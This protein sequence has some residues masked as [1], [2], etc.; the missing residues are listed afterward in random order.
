[1][2]CNSH[3]AAPQPT[4]LG[5]ALSAALQ[6]V[7]PDNPDVPSSAAVEE[8]DCKVYAIHMN[9]SAWGIPALRNAN[10]RFDFDRRLTTE[11]LYVGET[12][13]SIE[14][15]Y[16][17]HRTEGRRASTKWGRRHFKDS[18]REAYD[19]SIRKLRKEYG[20]ERNVDLDALTRS[21]ARYHEKHFAL[22]LRQ[23]GYAVYFA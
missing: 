21:E 3:P 4:S 2:N 16:R 8:R 23:R 22:W 9:P 15:R 17:V 20:K 13:K 14:E 7:V 19:R 1:M 10:P 11:P 18:F 5:Q 6:T 12:S